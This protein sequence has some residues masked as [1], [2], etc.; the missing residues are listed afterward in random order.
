MVDILIPSLNLFHYLFYGIDFDSQ[1]LAL[2]L[3]NVIFQAAAQPAFNG[4]DHLYIVTMARL[5]YA[6]VPDWLGDQRVVLV[7]DVQSAYR[8]L[9][10]GATRI[11]T[12]LIR[13]SVVARELLEMLVDGPEG[14]L[15]ISAYC[16]DETGGSQR[17][18]E[19]GEET[20]DDLPNDV[21][22]L[23]P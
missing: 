3:R 20:Q 22:D 18:E 2:D 16:G 13:S 1:S 7:E 12:L 19:T 11:S 21:M 5:G 14:D 15:V 4:I 8:L 10:R 23:D 6:D 9:S 17:Q